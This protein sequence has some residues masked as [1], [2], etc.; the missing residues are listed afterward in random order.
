MNKRTDALK[1]VYTAF[2]GSE[3]VS[4]INNTAEM[5]SKVAGVASGG[6]SGDF[7]AKMFGTYAGI[8][9]LSSRL[10]VSRIKTIS[11]SSD[12]I[13]DLR[14]IPGTSSYNTNALYICDTPIK[15]VLLDFTDDAIG[16]YTPLV[17]IP[18]IDFEG[19]YYTIESDENQLERLIER[20]SEFG[21]DNSTVPV[22]EIL[23]PDGESLYVLTNPGASDGESY[24][25]RLK[26][27]T[28]DAA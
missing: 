20:V 4:E 11:P 23:I 5:I 25:A 8:M 9:F 18:S 21:G 22:N 3:N 13:L 15:K 6:G 12:G 19:L 1:E 2:G 24:P 16:S 26:K 27:L 17:F 14:E 7:N 10:E 28:P